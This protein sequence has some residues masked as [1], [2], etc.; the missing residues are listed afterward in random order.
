M[1]GASAAREEQGTPK[2]RACPVLKGKFLEKFIE[3]P[4]GGGRKECFKGSR[5]DF[6]TG[7]GKNL[8]GESMI[9]ESIQHQGGLN[10]FVHQIGWTM[11]KK[12]K[13]RFSVAD[14][15]RRSRDSRDGGTEFFGNDKAVLADSEG[16]GL[17]NSG[18]LSAF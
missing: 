5:C 10:L 4:N 17:E 18:K 7:K 13:K 15:C 3:Q 16:G 9:G 12:I 2:D 14:S 1:E 8:S 6:G 11:S